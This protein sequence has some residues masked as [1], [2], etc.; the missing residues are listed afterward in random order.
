MFLARLRRYADLAP[1]WGNTDEELATPDAASASAQ[2]VEVAPA[3]APAPHV[4]DVEVN[5]RLRGRRLVEWTC[6]HD[7]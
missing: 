3:G 4:P 2:V 6:I 5:A 1:G 7:H